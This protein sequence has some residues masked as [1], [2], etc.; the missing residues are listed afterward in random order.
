M[1]I[2]TIFQN[3][4]LSGLFTF[5]VQYV[6]TKGLDH[7]VN[8]TQTKSAQEILSSQLLKCLRSAHK[9]TCA[10]FCCEYNDDVF[11]QTLK[12]DADVWSKL[13]DI[14]Q[15]GGWLS[16]VLVENETEIVT[17]EVA[18]FWL[19]TLE[20]EISCQQELYNYIHNKRT[21]PTPYAVNDNQIYIDA[22]DEALFMEA[23]LERTTNA[24]LR[25]V[26]I[27]PKYRILTAHGEK[28]I[29]IFET[30]KSF[31]THDNNALQQQDPTF[32][33]ANQKVFAVML[34]GKPGIGKS[35][36]VSYLATNLQYVLTNRPYH[37]VRLRNMLESQINSND[38]ITG[39]LSYM[40]TDSSGLENSVLILD[41]LDEICAIY[42]NT[43]FHT[44]LKRLL[45]D[46]SKI[47]GLQL[48]LTSR[49][50]YFHIDN[51]IKLH[52]NVITI[53]NWD[54]DDLDEWSAAYTRIHPELK[55]I[56]TS[57]K[58]HLQDAKYSGKRAIF[59][60]P[61]LFYMANARGEYLEKHSSICS[62]YDAVLSEVAGER[63]YDKSAYFPNQE[64]IT[65]KL[66]RQICREIAFT[67]FRHGRLSMFEHSVSVDPYLSPDEVNSAI[68][69]AIHIC[70]VS[71]YYLDDRSKQKIKDFYAL[72]FYYNKDNSNQNAVEFA[73]KTIA[74][75]FAAEKIIEILETGSVSDN[76]IKFNQTLAEC[77]GYAPI[78][79]DILIYIYEKIKRGNDITVTNQIKNCLERYALPG[80]LNGTLFLPPTKHKSDLHYID[81]ATIMIKSVL[82]IF[83]Y[84]DCDPAKV[85][86]TNNLEFNNLIATVS[87]A[88]AIKAHHGIHI[89]IALN[90]FALRDGDFSCGEF[91]EAHLSGADLNHTK[92]TDAN[93]IDAQLSGCV[94]TL[95]D[96]TGANLAGADLCNIKDSD[97]SDFSQASLQGADL[98][99]SFFSNTSFEAA[100][101]QGANLAGCVFEQ[102]CRFDDANLYHAE[103]DNADISQADITGALYE[104]TDDECDDE[105]FV[106]Y[107]LKLT[108]SQFD[109]F[110][111]FPLVELVE[112]IIDADRE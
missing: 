49:T 86:P 103:L 9:Q 7:L 69:D 58:E 24:T 62:V 12:T 13:S 38:P 74:E 108:Q 53:D 42:K 81:R 61:I 79:N 54:E 6:A 100:E 14:K 68:A 15:V 29:S 105:M 28:R 31:F 82:T 71:S 97:A 112:P 92:F 98:S 52:C 34:F 93:L 102:G 104:A 88:V 64:L 22:F 36:F 73:H 45:N 4:A 1:E 37:I 33:I 46:L 99:G 25:D 43:D 80:M 106:I 96:F 56:I 44:Y 89:P 95:A 47:N 76:E 32:S 66:A 26:Y 109:I 57:N 2:S 101:L 11:L 30:L 78:T 90:G 77:F 107:N 84:L 63:N 16:K 40:E 41:G 8:R 91:I 67:M 85:F 20:R 94:I 23:S 17:S 75:Y 111:S 19:N 50:G 51:Q 3:A 21:I 55:E 35:S 87:R 70:N 18:E 59:A 10:Q 65:P 27:P 48:V 83:E 72:T 39:L 60:V 5:L 110:S